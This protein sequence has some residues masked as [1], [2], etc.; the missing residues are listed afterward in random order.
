[1]EKALL[2]GG[3]DAIKWHIGNRELNH[4]IESLLPKLG[5]LASLL[6]IK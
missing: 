6:Q 1:M 4:E 5:G 3:F 2:S